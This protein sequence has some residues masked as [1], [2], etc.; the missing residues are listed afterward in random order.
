MPALPDLK[1]SQSTPSAEDIIDRL[2]NAGINTESAIEF[3][4]YNT[5]FYLELLGDLVSTSSEKLKELDNCFEVMDTDGYRTTVHSIKSSFRTLGLTE[6]AAF[7]QELENAARESDTEQLKRRHQS[8]KEQ[9]LKDID[10][11]KKL[12]EGG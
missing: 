9:Y 1:G 5:G 8:F 10:T 6:T 3:C 2:K 12:L 11:L 4:G 7:A